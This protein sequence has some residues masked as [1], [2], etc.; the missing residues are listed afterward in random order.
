[1]KFSDC[2]TT[3]TTRTEKAAARGPG[4]RVKHISRRGRLGRWMGIWWGK[5]GWDC[6]SG[7]ARDGPRDGCGG[8]RGGRKEREVSMG[9]R[10][11][12]FSKFRVGAGLRQPGLLHVSTIW[13]AIRI[14]FFVSFPRGP[15][16]IRSG[17]GICDILSPYYCSK[18]LY[19]SP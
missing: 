7:S 17:L 10:G 12:A 15:G 2:D 16:I 19:S 13:P 8:A 6:S 3:Q 18:L 4:S 11:W 5:D 14:R 9:C 1:M